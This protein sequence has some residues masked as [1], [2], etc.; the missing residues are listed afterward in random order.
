[1][2]IIPSRYEYGKKDE[3]NILYH[4]VINIDITSITLFQK[5]LNYKIVIV[6]NVCPVNG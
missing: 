2:Y 4:S 3:S 6:N 1:M 5:S